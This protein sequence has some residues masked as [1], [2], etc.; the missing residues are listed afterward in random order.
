MLNDG[1]IGT[2]IKYGIQMNIHFLTE[3]NLGNFKPRVNFITQIRYLPG[4]KNTTAETYSIIFH[5]FK[6]T[7]ASH[8][9]WLEAKRL[10]GKCSKER[11]FC[12]FCTFCSFARPV[13]TENGAISLQ[14]YRGRSSKQDWNRAIRSCY[15]AFDL[16]PRKHQN[17]LLF[18][19]PSQKAYSVLLI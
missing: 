11:F 10:Y 7:L 3:W 1:F 18:L 12:A 5:I 15:F 4:N 6:A 8:E 16:R 19:Q 9:L 13:N 2:F 17:E 14:A